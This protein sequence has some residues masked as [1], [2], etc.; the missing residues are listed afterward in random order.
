MLSH[1]HASAIVP[2]L[3]VVPPTARLSHSSTRSAPPASAAM[4]D[5]TSPTQI[6]ILVAEFT[7][8]SPA[9][10]VWIWNRSSPRRGPVPDPPAKSLQAGPVYG[11]TSVEQSN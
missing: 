2:A 8:G 4:A 6:S 10:I 3:G 11:L 5:S 1:R 7:V 9:T